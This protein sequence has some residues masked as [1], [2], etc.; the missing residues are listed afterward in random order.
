VNSF[1]LPIKR[2][3]LAKWIKKWNS[4]VGCLQES[5]LTGKDTHTHTHTHTHTSKVKRQKTII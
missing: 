1:S 5:H 3:R 4:T 2:Y